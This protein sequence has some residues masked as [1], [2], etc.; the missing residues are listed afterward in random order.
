MQSRRMVLVALVAAT[1]IV[2]P[3]SAGA[4]G[5]VAKTATG[6]VR[7]FT[8]DGADKF[9]GIPY[10][11]PPVGPRRWRAP[12]PA[13]GWHGIRDATHY[14]SRC[15]QLPSSNGPG[16]ENEDCL[17]LNVFRP[18]HR[19]RGRAPVLV[20]IH[21]GGLVNGSGD[22]HDGA[23][24]ARTNGIVV[25][26]FNYRLGVFGFLAHPALSA[27]APD[28]AS[29]D[30]GVLDQQ[31]ALR[32]VHRNIAGFGGDPRRVAIAGE[33]AGGWS[34]CAQ[35]AS[36]LT[37]GLFS[38]AAIQSGSCT[39]TPLDDAERAGTTFASGI[40]CSDAACLRSKTADELLA[41]TA[42]QQATSITWGGRELPIAPDKAIAGGR[43]NR[44]PVINGSNHDEG[45]TFAQ[46]LTDLD[47]QQYEGFVQSL[48]GD[49]APRV[50][51]QYPF[52]AYPSPYT[53]AYAIGAIWTDSGFVG[54]IGG[55]ATLALDRQLA[56][57]TRTYAYQFDDRNAPGLNHN[58]P[59]YMWGAGH[60]MELA[61]MWPSFDN[62]IPLAA[63]FTP[64]QRRLSREMVRYWGA[65]TRFG[66]PFAPFQA[67]WPAYRPGG[68]IQS[69]RPGGATRPV[70]EADY[71]EQHKCAFWAS[72]K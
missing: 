53:S 27:E 43:F 38:A 23:L 35:L 55:C 10:A 24:M 28:H 12:A 19:S 18:D 37:R 67:Y 33:S 72:L 50:L 8:A 3:A 46:D 4:H 71:A 61:Y 2:A 58:H 9:L 44:V 13:A 42:G 49:Q 60:A 5:P 56:R 52:S 25:V 47:E 36:P 68:R 59:G 6:L 31:A 22:Q 69:L 7:G 70:S 48:Y 29:G 62:G 1:M 64:A 26:S 66:V 57:W 21:G 16:S 30:Y 17:Y 51:E 65:L 14:G 40:G 34:V 63:Q 20:F 32:W 54:G 41:A 15:P 39:S 11:A 45:R